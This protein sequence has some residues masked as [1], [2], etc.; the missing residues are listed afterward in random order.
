VVGARAGPVAADSRGYFCRVWRARC[1][2]AGLF[3]R[4]DGARILADLERFGALN[5]GRPPFCAEFSFANVA[6][7]CPTAG[8][9]ACGAPSTG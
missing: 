9:C 3:W 4:R 2:R 6:Y 1:D 5:D 8:R 7:C